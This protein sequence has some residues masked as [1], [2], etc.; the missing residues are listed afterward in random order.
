MKIRLAVFLLLLVVVSCSKDKFNS[1]PTLTFKEMSGNYIPLGGDYGVQITMEYT[2]AEGDIAGVPLFIEKLSSSAS[3]TNPCSNGNEPYYTDSLSFTLPSD[4][5]ATTNQKGE[6]VV[7]IDGTMTAA[8][9][10]NPSDT[11]EQ[12][13]FKFWFRDQAGNMTDT[14]TSPPITIQKAP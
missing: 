13:T 12:A 5:P 1:K 8:L 10:C 14:V 2:D 3:P 6:V 7:T 11:L 9:S 4:V